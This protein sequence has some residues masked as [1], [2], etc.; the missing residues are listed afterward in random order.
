MSRNVSKIV[1]QSS[2]VDTSLPYDASTLSGKTILI[3]GGASGFGEG[4]ARHWAAQGATIIIGDIDDVR[5]KAIA[6]ALCKENANNST[7]FL[8]CDVTNWQSQVD[9]FHDALKLSPTGGI[10]SVVA[11]AGITDRMPP[12]SQPVGLDAPEPP[13][14]DLKCMDVNLTGVLYTT[15]LAMFY[16]PRNPGSKGANSTT[17]PAAGTPD[18]H[19]L[20]VGSVASISPLPII[21]QYAASKHAVLGLFR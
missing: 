5:G 2:P 4:F 1:R 21:C 14:P 9:F 8:H 11:N 19:L 7:H 6:Q 17:L 15:H 20:L 10:D 12:L 16:L 3:T 13:E 18:R